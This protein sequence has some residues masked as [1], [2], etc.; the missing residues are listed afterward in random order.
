MISDVQ[1]I[2]VV[3]QTCDTLPRHHTFNLQE[4]L[5]IP[6]PNA[7][8]YPVYV[9]MDVAM[10]A[11]MDAPMDV[12]MGVLMDVP[13]MGLCFS[14]FFHEVSMRFCCQ[15]PLAHSATVFVMCMHIYSLLFEQCACYAGCRQDNNEE[16][17][18]PKAQLSIPVVPHKAV[19]EVSK[20]GNL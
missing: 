17:E 9:P 1:I 19:A 13:R 5:D 11:P 8:T 4:G 2:P 18:V 14:G 10:D 20:I 7:E 16:S 3:L 15:K 6:E 12:L